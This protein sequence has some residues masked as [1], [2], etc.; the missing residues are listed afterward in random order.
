M[1]LRPPFETFTKPTCKGCYALGTACGKCER[2]Q[3]ERNQPGFATYPDPVLKSL[4]KDL[5]TAI[6]AFMKDPESVEASVRTITVDDKRAATIMIV[7]GDQH[8]LLSEF[9]LERVKGIR[10]VRVM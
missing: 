10:K 1:S 3:W 8:E 4:S 5:D 2:C 9:L 6:S 7:S